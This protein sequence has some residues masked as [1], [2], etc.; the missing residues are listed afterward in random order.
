MASVTPADG[1]DL[2]DGP[3]MAVYIGGAG[4]L[5]VTTLKGDTLVISGLLAGCVY[6]FRVSRIWSTSTTATNIIAMY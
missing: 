4:N 6:P 2:P 3:S 1:S 5:K